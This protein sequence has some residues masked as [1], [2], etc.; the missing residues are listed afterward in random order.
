MNKSLQ[1][2]IKA[3]YIHKNADN[4]AKDSLENLRMVSLVSL[5]ISGIFT[6]LTFTFYPDHPLVYASLLYIYL[7]LITFAYLTNQMLKSGKIKPKQVYR[8]TLEFLG[9]MSLG[10]IFISVYVINDFLAIFFILFLVLYPTLFMLKEVHMVLFLVGSGVVFLIGSYFNPGRPMSVFYID[11]YLIST[12]L[13]IGVPINWMVLKLRRKELYMKELFVAYSHLDE[14]TKLP[15]RRAFNLHIEKVFNYNKINQIPLGVALI[16]IDDFKQYNDHYG[17]LEGDVILE[18]LGNIIQNQVKADTFFARFGGEEFIGVFTNQS[19]E[20][21]LEILYNIK[22]ELQ[23]LDIINT[24][25][26]QKLSISIGV[27]NEKDLS[28]ISYMRVI[29]NA[30]IALYKSKIYGKDKIELYTEE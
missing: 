20:S 2:E 23:K 11:L 14:L 25:T 24:M 8:M 15:N 22:D 13:L 16:D 19:T 6:V 10:L 18:K 7:M 5:A 12:G 3:S 29:D 26:N 27:C 28:N 4:L 1:D 17:H 30:D 21:I 9:M